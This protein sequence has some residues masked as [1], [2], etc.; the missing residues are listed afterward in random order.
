VGQE[1][2]FVSDLVADF[3]VSALLG[4]AAP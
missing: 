2:V 3:P 4:V 1:R